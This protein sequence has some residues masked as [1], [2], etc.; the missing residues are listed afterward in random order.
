MPA[1]F[2]TIIKLAYLLSHLFSCHQAAGLAV[3]LPNTQQLCCVS[4]RGALL[5]YCDIP[6]GP[7]FSL[8]TNACF[9]HSA[10][11]PLQLKL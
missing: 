7:Q 10:V 6:S 9:D 5:C 3:E 2:I 8:A 11:H 1:I 4:W